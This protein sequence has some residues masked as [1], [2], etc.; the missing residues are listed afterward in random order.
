M[1]KE[2]KE[3]EVKVV[4]RGKVVVL[5]IK[6]TDAQIAWVMADRLIKRKGGPGAKVLGATEKKS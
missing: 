2:D 5:P 6:A 1:A 4:V 3:F